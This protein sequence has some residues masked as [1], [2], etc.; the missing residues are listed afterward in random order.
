M[1]AM[2]YL[3]QDDQSHYVHHF[4][5]IPNFHP[6]LSPSTWLLVFRSDVQ[7]APIS[8]LP[9]DVL[10]SI[11]QLYM[12]IEAIDFTLDDSVKNAPWI[13]ARICKYWRDLANGSP[14]LWANPS[15]R[16]QI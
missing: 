11:F 5:Q 2:D 15:L 3:G 14:S 12:G 6:R 4:L 7:K 13:I 9:D 1:A 16:F 10:L 8:R